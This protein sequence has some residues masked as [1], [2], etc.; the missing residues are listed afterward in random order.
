[1]YVIG[2]F[3]SK[4]QCLVCGYENEIMDLQFRIDERFALSH[5]KLTSRDCSLSTEL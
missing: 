5:I 4:V 3:D 2:A 1:M